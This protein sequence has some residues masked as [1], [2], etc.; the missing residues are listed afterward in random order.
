M[1]SLA[2]KLKELHFTQNQIHYFNRTCVGDVP[3][4][5][6]GMAS[7][8]YIRVTLIYHL[9]F[10]SK[11]MPQVHGDAEHSYKVAPVTMDCWVGLSWHHG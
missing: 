4:S 8:Y 2:S 11:Q 5:V 7:A 3:F 6:A 1:Y 10:P 9:T